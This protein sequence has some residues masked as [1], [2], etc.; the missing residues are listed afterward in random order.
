MKDVREVVDIVLPDGLLRL[1]WPERVLPVDV[2]ALPSFR[3]VVI[4][5]RFRLAVDRHGTPAHAIDQ[6]RCICFSRLLRA[7]MQ[8]NVHSSR[9]KI[10]LG[11]RARNIRR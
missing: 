5:K 3:I 6:F 7:K 10:E 2:E 4:S 1:L 11:L 8:R 9:D